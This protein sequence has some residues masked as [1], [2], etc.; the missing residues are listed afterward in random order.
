MIKDILDSLPESLTEVQRLEIQLML[1]KKVELTDGTAAD[2][3]LVPFVGK[4]IRFL[5]ASQRTIW[6]FATLWIDTQWFFG[7]F[8]FNEQQQTALIVIN[9]M[10]LGFLFGERTVQNLAPLLIARK[11]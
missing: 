3:H 8:S 9:L 4:C 6:G 1:V 5:R 2:L 10:V 11:K 7:S